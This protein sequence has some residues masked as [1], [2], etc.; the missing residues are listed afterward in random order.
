MNFKRVTS[1]TAVAILVA[2]TGACSST[3]TKMATSDVDARLQAVKDREAA[4]A[5]KEAQLQARAAELASTPAPVAAAPA[6]MAAGDALLPPYAKPGECYARIFIPAKFKTVTE[7]KLKKGAEEKVELI[8]AKYGTV[9]ERVLVQEESERLEVIPATYK[10]VTERVLVKPEGKKLVTVPAKYENQSERVMVKEAYTT[11]KKGRGPIQ[12]LDES[13]GEIMCLVEVPAEYKTIT[14]R[15]MVTPPTTSEV[16]IPAQYKTVTKRVVDRTASTRTVKIPAKYKTVTITKM[17]QPPQERRS[18]IPETYQSVTKTV[19]VSEGMMEWREILCDTN[20]TRGK[21]TEIQKSLAAKGFNP[22]PIDGVVG[23]ET[24]R[25][26]NAFQK[27]TS[28]PVS[29]YV[30]VKT[31]EALGVNPR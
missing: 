4:L 23:W 30:T 5:A 16:A 20:M 6:P 12:R 26:V 24:M 17:T 18:T 7:R 29:R 1:A 9:T 27:K 21:V 19:K 8:P 22:G 25:A 15:V 28:L 14:K 10:T 2:M 11:W 13:T 3:G 31:A